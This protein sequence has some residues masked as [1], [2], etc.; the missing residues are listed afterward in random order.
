MDQA[1]KNALAH[2]LEKRAGFIDDELGSNL[3]GAKNVANNFGGTLWAGSRLLNPIMMNNTTSQAGKYGLVGGTAGAVG[4]AGVG[5]Y[6]GYKGSEGMNPWLRAMMTASGAGLGAT[7]GGA[8]GA[9]GGAGL[10][11]AIHNPWRTYQQ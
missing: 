10:G 3:Q 7:V 11:A 9:A 6:M 2:R 4:G 5:G 1:L 8:A